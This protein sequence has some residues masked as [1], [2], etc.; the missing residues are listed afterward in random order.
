MGD[1]FT[2]A[3]VPRGANLVQDNPGRPSE[4]QDGHEIVLFRFLSDLGVV[5]GPVY[6]RF[7]SSGTLKFRFFSGLFPGHLFSDS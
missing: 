1:Y 6:I 2:T 7:L 5:L 4:Q 3:G